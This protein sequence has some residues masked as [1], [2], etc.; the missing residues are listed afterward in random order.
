MINQG[1]KRLFSWRQWMKYISWHWNEGLEHK[2]WKMWRCHSS[3]FFYKIESCML[4]GIWH[5]MRIWYEKVQLGQTKVKG[6]KKSN[7]AKKETK[8]L[9]TESPRS[10]KILVRSN[11]DWV[12]ECIVMPSHKKTSHFCFFRVPIVVTEKVRELLGTTQIA[13]AHSP[14]QES[15]L[16]V[17]KSTKKGKYN[18]GDVSNVDGIMHTRLGAFTIMTHYKFLSVVPDGKKMEMDLYSMSIA[19]LR[20]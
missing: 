14:V 9:L 12:F 2:L 8:R 19:F 15:F 7:Y 3:L 20:K 1:K 18:W 16:S 17:T 13:T 5:K 4:V 10:K 11:L 6:T